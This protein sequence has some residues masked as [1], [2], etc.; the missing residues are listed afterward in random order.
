MELALPLPLDSAAQPVLLQEEIRY[1]IQDG[2]AVYE[3]DVKRED[4]K[5]GILIVTSHR[6]CWIDSGRRRP[7][8]WHLSHVADVHTEEGS[9]F[10]G[11]PKIVLHLRLPPTKEQLRAASVP[12]AYPSL[13]A[14]GGQ[15][16]QQS[17]VSKVLIWSTA[18]TEI[19]LSFYK[20]GRDHALDDLRK[21]LQRRAWEAVAVAPP[22]KELAVKPE[23]VVARPGIAGLLERRAAAQAQSSAVASAAFSDLDELARHARSLVAMAEQYA[24]EAARKANSSSSSGSVGAGAGSS[25]NNNGSLGGASGSLPADSSSPSASASAAADADVS[26]AGSLALN[27]GLLSNPITRSSAGNLFYSELARQVA[28][29][30]RPFLERSGGLLPLTDVYCL[31]NR[32][33]RT[34]LI[35]PDDL[36]EACQLMGR[37]RLGMALRR[38]TSGS[39]TNSGSDASGGGGLLVLQLDSFSNEGAGRRIEEL[40][41][42]RAS[43]C[44]NGGPLPTLT[45]QHLLR[46]PYVTAVE[47]NALWRVPLPVAQQLL[48]VSWVHRSW[49]SPRTGGYGRE[50]S[51]IM[52]SCPSLSSI[53]PLFSPSLNLLLLLQ[54]A[55]AQ[56]VVARDE[57]VSGLRWYLNRFAELELPQLPP[58][59]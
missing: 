1:R 56:G 14:S 40:L 22:A 28:S 10:I 59:R 15:Q 44:G 23:D 26:S 42:S 13:P 30:A 18:T 12:G 51:F 53:A 24:G 34:D 55:E 3:R 9:L 47:L 57:S 4:L 45:A 5:D 8:G 25:S 11:H 6:V 27:I 46:E 58:E 31:Y 20:G 33:R 21:A 29:F 50:S 16:Q 54:A 43:S 35:S 17:A 52:T 38:L 37:L 32:A 49:G 41:R 7:L 19:R 48:L 2:I 36:L 39:T